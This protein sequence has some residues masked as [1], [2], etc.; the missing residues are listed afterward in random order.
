MGSPT[1]RN[2]Q[3][4]TQHV[5]PRGHQ[6]YRGQAA[7]LGA[8]RRGQR[9]G[10]PVGSR[11]ILIPEPGHFLGRERVGR[12]AECRVRRPGQIVVVDAVVEDQGAYARSAA[13]AQRD[14]DR[15]RQV[16]ARR[17]PGQRRRSGQK[18]EFVDAAGQAANRG[19]AGVQRTS[20]R[21]NTARQACGRCSI[22]CRATCGRRCCG[23]IAAS[24]TRRSC[25]RRR[26]GSFR[27]S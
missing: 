22:V 26:H 3:T 5:L 21:P 7:Q 13:I 12:Q 4:K 8:Q 19:D 23:A 14:R 2:S 15:Q 11:A 1:P 27:F 24:A 18:P 6:P 9:V 16:G 25:A 10:S 17:V 20:M